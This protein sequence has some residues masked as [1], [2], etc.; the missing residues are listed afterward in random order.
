MQYAFQIVGRHR[1]R[2][3]NGSS[4]CQHCLRFS[5]A[6]ITVWGGSGWDFPCIRL[7]P[8]KWQ[9][10]SRVIEALPSKTM[11]DGVFNSLR[12]LPAFLTNRLHVYEEEKEGGKRLIALKKC[13]SQYSIDFI[14]YNFHKPLVWFPFSIFK[15]LCHCQKAK[16]LL[17]YVCD[18][19]NWVHYCLWQRHFLSF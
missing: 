12:T 2:F 5:Y 11:I 18:I 7:Y 6:N 10:F 19:I 16:L 1:E 13:C 8:W 9:Y 17:C 3:I 4:S 14:H 15:S